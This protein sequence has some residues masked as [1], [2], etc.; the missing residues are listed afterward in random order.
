MNLAGPATPARAQGNSISTNLWSPGTPR[1]PEEVARIRFKTNDYFRAW[2]D[3]RK[4][5]WQPPQ[6]L[7]RLGELPPRRLGAWSGRYSTARASVGARRRRNRTLMRW[8]ESDPDDRP[9]GGVEAPTRKVL[10]RLSGVSLK[11]FLGVGGEGVACLVEV[12]GRQ[13]GGSRK[14]VIKVSLGDDDWNPVDLT[15]EKKW[16]FRLKRAKHVV[17]IIKFADLRGTPN[18]P[19]DV[20]VDADPKIYFMELMK[21]GNLDAVI[22]RAGNTQEKLPSRLLWKIFACCVLSPEAKNNVSSKR[23]IPR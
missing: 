23:L 8:Y 21:R 12:A 22:G 13:G 11:R 17:Q 18:T 16:H 14:A 1:T 10:A 7:M 15:T 19:S 3:G 20:L 6:A 5:E 2:R 4:E 9:P